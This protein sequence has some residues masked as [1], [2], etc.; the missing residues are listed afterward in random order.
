MSPTMLAIEHDQFLRKDD[1]RHEIR[2]LTLY[3]TDFG[4]AVWEGIKFLDDPHWFSHDMIANGLERDMR[5]RFAER[6]KEL[7][8]DGFEQCKL[9]H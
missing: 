3:Q 7:E 6:M 2:E 5:K 1:P 4:F 8:Q 9:D